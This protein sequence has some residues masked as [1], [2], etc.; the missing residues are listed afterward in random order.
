[1]RSRRSLAS[2]AACGL[3]MG[4]MAIGASGAQAGMWMV[5]KANVGSGAKLKVELLPELVT[6]EGEAGDIAFLTTS[7]GNKVRYLCS[8]ASSQVATVELEFLT[9]KFHF[10][11]CTTYINDARKPDC[12]PGSIDIAGTTLPVLHEKKPYIEITGVEGVLGVLKV[13]EEECLV[14]PSVMKLTGRFWLEDVN[15]ELEKEKVIHALREA[16]VPAGKLGGL[17]IGSNA[18]TFD[19]SF[20]LSFSDFSHQGMTWSGLA[21]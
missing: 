2:L 16:K 15:G 11:N 21:L 13:D 12:D 9:Y 10:F 3:A 14:L 17:L 18:A 1:M 20:N 4:L 19:G 5:N 6:P 7:G 8:T